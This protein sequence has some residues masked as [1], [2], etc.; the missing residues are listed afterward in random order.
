MSLLIDYKFRPGIAPKFQDR[1]NI[2]ECLYADSK[3]KPTESDFRE[4]DRLFDQ[5]VI[6]MTNMYE[7]LKDRYNTFFTKFLTDQQRA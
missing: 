2:V 4:I 6:V 5:Y 7:I 1:S 3:K